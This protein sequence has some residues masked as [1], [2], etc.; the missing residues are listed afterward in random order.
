MDPGICQRRVSVLDLTEFRVGQ[1]KLQ[2]RFKAGLISV[3]LALDHLRYGGQRFIVDLPQ[4]GKRRAQSAGEAGEHPVL[5]VS[6]LHHVGDVVS[7]N[8]CGLQLLGILL[9][10][11]PELRLVCPILNGGQKR[12]AGKPAEGFQP[13]GIGLLRQKVGVQIVPQ[14]VGKEAADDA[15][16]V[17]P[18]PGLGDEG[19]SGVDGDVLVVRVGHAGIFRLPDEVHVDAPLIMVAPGLGGRHVLKVSR[20]QARGKE[21]TVGDLAAL[22]IQPLLDQLVIDSCHASTSYTADLR[23]FGAKMGSSAVLIRAS[24]SSSSDVALLMMV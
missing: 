1:Q 2:L 9:E 14:L 3:F 15:V 23:R 20:K 17:F 5:D 4:L 11:V 22:L 21:L 18:A 24:R 10:V 8:L 6:V 16:T 19:V 13:V 7:Q 12:R